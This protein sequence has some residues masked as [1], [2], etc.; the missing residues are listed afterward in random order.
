MAMAQNYQPL[1]MDS[2]EYHTTTKISL[3]P[4]LSN[5]MVF[6]GPN[7]LLFLWIQIDTS[8][9]HHEIGRSKGLIQDG[10]IHAE[11]SPT[12]P[13]S[14]NLLGGFP[15]FPVFPMSSPDHQITNATV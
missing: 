13:R 3:T 8:R 4:I 2:G 5:I 15:D 12:I 11:A 6:R 1:K 9:I 10:V 14:H 7:D